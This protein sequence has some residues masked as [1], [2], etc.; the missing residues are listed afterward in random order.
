MG[1]AFISLAWGGFL[2]LRNLKLYGPWLVA[3]V[4]IASCSFFYQLHIA[5]NLPSVSP[6]EQSQYFRAILG[7]F[8][9]HRGSA[10]LFHPGVYL[11][12]FSV[13]ISLLML[14]CYRKDFDMYG[15][16]LLRA[17]VVSG[18][19]SLVG[20]AL[21]WFPNKVPEILLI[22]MPG[23]FI[24]LSILASS[25]LI[26]GLMGRY[27][28]LPLVRALIFF[29]LLYVP[30]NWFIVPFFTNDK[31]G[32]RLEHWREIVVVGTLLLALRIAKT[33]ASKGLIKPHY[34]RYEARSGS[35]FNLELGAA[36]VLMLIGLSWL[37]LLDKSHHLS[38]FHPQRS[39]VLSAASN[40]RGI[41]ITAPGMELVQLRTRRPLLLNIASL[42][43]ISYFP[44]SG[45]L[46]N[47]ALKSVYGV[48]LLTTTPITLMKTDAL[49]ESR[50]LT[51]WQALRRDFGATDVLV[52][53]DNELQLPH[54]VRDE[55][56]ALYHIPAST[57]QDTAVRQL[58]ALSTPWV[59]VE[60]PD[61]SRESL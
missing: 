7:S 12:I 48:D 23:R 26:L 29:H 21:T 33:I 49:W 18:A 53:S 41:L 42:D 2:T 50:T 36:L 15:C 22:C 31:Y 60:P 51:E 55:Q 46:A 17:M 44:A 45:A 11:T 14:S 43:Q 4:A 38:P 9:V 35:R 52:S 58:A 16:F 8:D 34:N 40:G 20:V 13:F 47:P 5:R 30:F 61:T 39:D 1:V 10:P 25:A 54:T 6:E 27:W 19:L 59:L 56:F 37:P 24:N 28:H 57:E 32:W 3:G